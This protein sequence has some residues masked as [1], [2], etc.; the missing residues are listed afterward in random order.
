[1][2]W[3][4][5]KQRMVARSSTDVEYQAIVSTVNEVHWLTSLLWELGHPLSSPPTLWC[6]NL[7]ATYLTSNPIFHSR[8]KHLEIDFHFVRDKV[9]NH[10]LHVKYISSKDQIADVLTK[11]LPKTTFTTLK[12]KLSVFPPPVQLAG[13]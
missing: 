10:E 9:L 11:P 1:M 7:S 4:S 6:D 12:S 3:G 13:G 2:A 8:S 5:K